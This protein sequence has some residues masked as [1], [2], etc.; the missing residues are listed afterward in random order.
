MPGHGQCDGD[1]VLAAKIFRSRFLTRSAHN[2][3]SEKCG[4]IARM[5]PSGPRQAKITA[6]Q[7]ERLLAGHFKE[8][9]LYGASRS[10]LKCVRAMMWGS[11]ARRNP[12]RQ[13]R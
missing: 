2:R 6:T 1:F 5:T 4:K 8:R 11:R 12:L 7:N 9:R 3:T 10:I 13:E